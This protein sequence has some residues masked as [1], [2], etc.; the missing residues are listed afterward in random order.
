M[1]KR[2][3][4]VEALISVQSTLKQDIQVWAYVVTI[5]T[6]DWSHL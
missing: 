4:V 6:F 5:R 1:L 2:F 3:G